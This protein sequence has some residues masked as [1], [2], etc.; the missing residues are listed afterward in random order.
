MRGI[1]GP[2]P[3]GTHGIALLNRVLSWNSEGIQYEADQRHVE[4][5]L[6]TTGYQDVK[7]VVTPGINEP[8]SA[9]QE[10]DGEPLDDVE[11]SLF[12]AAAASCNFLGLDRPDMQHS[13][14]ECCRFMSKPTRG[15]LRTLHILC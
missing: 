7:G 6:E 8:E 1:L 13:A 4:I 12:R 2:D 15:D 3:R 5:L 11:A 10:D 14:K 9:V